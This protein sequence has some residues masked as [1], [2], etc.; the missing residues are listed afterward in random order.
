VGERP[1]QGL[2]GTIGAQTI[3]ITGRRQMAERGQAASLPPVAGG[4]ECHVLVDGT[5]TATYRFHDAP[6][7]DSRKFV[8]HLRPEHGV[9]RVLLVTGDRDEEARYLAEVVGIEE[10]HAGK[11]PEEKVAIT[12]AETAR[13]PTLFLG[14]GINDAPALLTATVGVAFGQRAEVTSEAAGAVIM[15]ASL[16]RVDELLHISRRMR[17]IALQSAVGGMAL[18]VV[19]M[20]FASAGYLPPVAGAVV[21]EVIDLAAVLN[22]LRAALPGGR[23]SDY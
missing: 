9:T 16:R 5:Y 15:D 6:R 10:V 17:R 18:S 21:Q 13:A 12:R 23:I 2:V 3:E 19:G 20:V 14:D 8:H 4:L 1:G 11:S 7:E 22:A